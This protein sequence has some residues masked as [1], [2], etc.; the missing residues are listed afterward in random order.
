MSAGDPSVR[1]QVM[2]D[3]LGRPEDQVAVERA[4]VATE[5]WGAQLLAA[6]DPD[7]GWAGALYSPKWTSTTYTLLLLQR[8]GLEQGYPRALAGV[9]SC[10]MA[11][12]GTAV[13]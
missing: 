10:G 7:G 8:L 5:G 6:Q 9:G 12:A 3:L 2:R 11:H 13:V 1:W 4:R